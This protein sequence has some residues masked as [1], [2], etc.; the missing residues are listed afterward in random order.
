[1]QTENDVDGDS[2]TVWNTL[3]SR[4]W[5]KPGASTAEAEDHSRVAG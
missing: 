2:R 3:A 5:W 4:G 1:M